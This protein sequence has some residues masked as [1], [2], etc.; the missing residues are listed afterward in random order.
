MGDAANPRYILLGRHREWATLKHFGG[1]DS[2]RIK[3]ANYKISPGG[4]IPTPGPDGPT[5]FQFI[6]TPKYMANT[7]KLDAVMF[8]DLPLTFWDG[9]N[10]V[11]FDPTSP[12]G[13]TSNGQPVLIRNRDFASSPNINTSKG[14]G[15][16]K[17]LG[18]FPAGAQGFYVTGT[19]SLPVYFCF[20]ES[21]GATYLSQWN[22]ST[23]NPLR[24]SNLL[25]SGSYG[26]A[27]ANPYDSSVIY[28]ITSSA[29]VVSTNGGTNFVPDPS[30]TAL[31][32]GPNRASMDIL[33]CISFNYANPAEVVAGTVDGRLFFKSVSSDWIELTSLLPTP[34]SPIVSVAIDCEAIY[35]AYAGRSLVRVVDCNDG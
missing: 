10:N 7:G 25:S 23:W 16:D 5:T 26:P 6:Q 8:V 17:E 3:L 34:R 2:I 20:G 21:G 9:N 32:S 28:A 35:A 1:T 11:P 29:I 31:L 18:N 24:L 22:G 13:Q 33:R 19:P 15:W 12:L 27:F 14:A 30:L 4:V